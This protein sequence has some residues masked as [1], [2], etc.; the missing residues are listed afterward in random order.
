MAKAK[1][2]LVKHT[3]FNHSTMMNEPFSFRDNDFNLLQLRTEFSTLYQ[4]FLANE[5]HWI[6]NE[7]LV[8]YIRYICNLLIS[9]YEHDY[10]NLEL[11]KLKE[12]KDTLDS[13]IEKHN[14][15]K[16][17]AIAPY[18][19]NEEN[20]F[21]FI[22]LSKLNNEVSLLNSKRSQFNYSRTLATAVI[23][24]LQAS[25]V[26]DLIYEL[27]EIL[28]NRYS[29]IE[30]LNL[31]N[32]SRE[33]ITLLGIG[34]FAIRLL[35]NLILMTKHLLQAKISKEL[36][37]NKVFKQELEQRGFVIAS[38]LVW[39]FVGILTTFNNLF[40]ISSLVIA[41]IVLV[42][43]VFDTLLLLSQWYYEATKYQARLQ[44]FSSQK[45]KATPLEL[46]MINRQID[47][48]NDE[49]EVQCAYYAI[50]ILGANILALSFAI[51][52]LYSLP[53]VLAGLALC[54]M[55]GNALYNTAEEYKR[56]QHFKIAVKRE[57]ANGLIV[58]D[59]HH[60]KL[61][62][63]L[64]LEC[65]KHYAAFWKSLTFNMG[66]LAFI[67]TAAVASW[68]VALVLTLSYVGY[69]LNKVYHKQFE[70]NH[71]DITHNVYRFVEE[72]AQEEEPNLLLT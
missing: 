44:E 56:Y 36:S 15:I 4:L 42:F 13:F 14:L 7:E 61:L 47:I 60:D 10:L 32:K 59:E 25:T 27:N 48:L 34:L 18:P 35:I 3:F 55:L 65:H 30:G 57:T 54:S 23:G 68:P 28:G 29:F 6:K 63:L 70:K 16:T 66:G 20:R 26:S 33:V 46:I 52:M 8:Y 11:E 24:Y 51:S 39:C 64:S 31:L 37:A 67:I 50:N 21:N 43:L 9:Y 69:Q 5:K 58:H 71:K 19:H 62:V 17:T 45:E 1:I 2:S 41:P 72:P 40:N 22:N 12:H 53:I 38:D 49:W